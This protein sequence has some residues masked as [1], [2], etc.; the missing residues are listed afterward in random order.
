MRSDLIAEAFGSLETVV[1]EILLSGRFVMAA[2]QQVTA[3]MGYLL[4]NFSSVVEH[5]S[6]LYN[7]RLG[8]IQL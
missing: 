7:S 8:S 5:F 4:Q 3:A 2:E 6:W 1:V